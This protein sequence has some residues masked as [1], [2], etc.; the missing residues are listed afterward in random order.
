MQ[1]A[2]ARYNRAF[3]FLL[4]LKY[5]TENEFT[6][7]HMA[8]PFLPMPVFILSVSL[9]FHKNKQIDSNVCLYPCMDSTRILPKTH[10]YHIILSH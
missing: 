6:I 7:I 10:C 3:A 9:C 4:K 1:K 8:M 5:F 2:K